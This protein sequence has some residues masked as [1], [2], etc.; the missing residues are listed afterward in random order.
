MTP[1]PPRKWLH[2]AP[3]IRSPTR[4]G[5]YLQLS[6]LHAR[7]VIGSSSPDKGGDRNGVSKQPIAALLW[8]MGEGKPLETLAGAEPTKATQH[9]RLAKPTAHPAP[10]ASPSDPALPLAAPRWWAGSAQALQPA[11]GWLEGSERCRERH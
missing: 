9:P 3:W 6:Q 1:K 10:C 4:V 2:C 8:E 7:I 11:P 5:L